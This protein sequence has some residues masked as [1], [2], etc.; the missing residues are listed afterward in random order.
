[1]LEFKKKVLRIPTLTNGLKVLRISTEAIGSSEHFN[2]M[3]PQKNNASQHNDS[4]HY[5]TQH[6]DAQNNDTQDNG[7]QD[8]GTQNNGIQHKYIYHNDS[9]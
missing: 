5:D 3:V 2:I 1:M 9:A 7:T 8:N 4:Q 6:N